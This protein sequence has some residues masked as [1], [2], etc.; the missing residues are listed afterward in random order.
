MSRNT[1]VPILILTVLFAACS[2]KPKPEP[3]R[4]ELE[5]KIVG[6]DAGAKKLTV[7]HKDIPGLMKAMTMDFKVKDSGVFGYAKKGD[8]ISAVL[9][10]DQGDSY[11]E[12]VVIVQ[13]TPDSGVS[14]SPVH[15]PQV[16]DQVPD[17]T[18]TNQSGKKDTLS[19]LRGRP[20]LLTFI[21]TR[22]PL[23]DYCVR[24]SSNFADI[25]KQL[26]QTQPK[27]YDKL[28]L[29]SVSID[30]EFD[31]PKVLAAYGKNYAGQV[32]PKFTRWWFVTSSPD[33]TKTFANFFGLS[34]MKQENQI[35]HSL[36]TALIG[37]DG[38]IAAIYNG[39]DWRAA[40]VIKDLQGLK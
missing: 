37:P 20:V 22:C 1:L 40:D 25:E 31:T 33:E 7:A 16:G 3:K 29:V 8:Q 19:A 39:N 24:M 23:P 34:Y 32:D 17:F 18:F 14:T 10:M 9:V 21:Y 27:L 28:Q 11:L 36:R 30:P 35:V 6:V 15:L 38:K 2:S 5:G 13:N 4:Y 26:K 12:D